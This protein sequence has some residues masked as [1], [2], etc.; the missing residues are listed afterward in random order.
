MD[1]NQTVEATT[2]AIKLHQSIDYNQTLLAIKEAT[3]VKNFSRFSSLLEVAFA[4]NVS[5]QLIPNMYNIGKKKIDDIEFSK[6]QEWE[7]KITELTSKIKEL[8]PEDNVVL[9]GNEEKVKEYKD[10]IIIY[11]TFMATIKSTSDES[12]PSEIKSKFFSS[13]APYAAIVS[14]ILLF[15]GS[16]NICLMDT[17]SNANRDWLQTSI[18]IILLSPNIIALGFQL[19]HWRIIKT[20]LTNV[21]DALEK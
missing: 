18:I 5:Y 7:S 8:T 1:F 17:F 6:I 4:I 3:E 15:S 21:I 12:T 9:E 11:K 2:L 14:I 10:T 13:V 19:K 20:K 16:L